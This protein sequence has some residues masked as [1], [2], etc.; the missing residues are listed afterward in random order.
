MSASL[1]GSEMCIRDSIPTVTTAR[2]DGRAS[3][4]RVVILQRGPRA[5]KG[6]HDVR[7][8][9]TASGDMRGVLS[10]QL[11]AGGNGLSSNE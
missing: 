5:V 2:P 6:D 8:A 9:V 4:A 7:A 1:V 10:E 11:T 3:A